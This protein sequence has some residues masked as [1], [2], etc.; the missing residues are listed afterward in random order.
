MNE[1]IDV[2]GSM[3]AREIQKYARRLGLFV[4]SG[5]TL[6]I[7]TLRGIINFINEKE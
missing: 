5:K 3:S 4:E 1:N 2:R 7:G 6:A